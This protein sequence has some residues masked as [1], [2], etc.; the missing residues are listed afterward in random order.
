MGSYNGYPVKR[1]VKGGRVR[2]DWN[3]TTAEVRF[4]LSPN[5]YIQRERHAVTELARRRPAKGN[6]DD[7]IPD[8][9]STASP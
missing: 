3:P 7:C 1:K 4:P 8:R 9:L 2:E 5:S 6:Q